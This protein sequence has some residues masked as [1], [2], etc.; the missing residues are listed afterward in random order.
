MSANK[1]QLDIA[2]TDD[3]AST[4]IHV[5]GPGGCARMSDLGC[6]FDK[7][8]EHL[9]STQQGR[10]PPGHLLRSDA[11]AAWLQLTSASACLECLKCFALSSV[12]RHQAV[13]L[14]AGAVRQVLT[15]SPAAPCHQQAVAT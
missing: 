15:S 4:V 12:H 11:H 2:I 13:L 1:Q 6:V 5:R 9:H 14:A 8:G 3:D 10:L 7:L